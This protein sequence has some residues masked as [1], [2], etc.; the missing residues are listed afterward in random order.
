MR[1]TILSLCFFALAQ[2]LSAQ[3]TPTPA[4]ERIK[5]IERRKALEAQS[6]VQNVPFRNIGP[7]V[8]SGRVVDVDVNPNDPTEFYVAY[9][10]GGLWYTRNNGQSFKPLFDHEDVIGIGDIAV[11]WKNRQIWIGTGEVNSSRSSYPGL[12]MYFSPDSGNTWQYKG[13]PES[14]HIG[15]VVL[16]PTDPNTVWVA[17]L[18]HLFSPSSERGVFKTTDGG[19]S[20]KH[21]LAVDENTGAVEVQ[22][23]PKNPSVLYA[24]MWHRERRTWNF[25]ESGTTSGMYKSTDGGVQ[26][27]KLSVEGSGF[28]TGDGVGRIGIAVFP[29]NT[30]ILYAVV[31]NQSKRP[32]EEPKDTSVLT[33]LDL[34][35]MD[36]QQLLNTRNKKLE[37][38]LR[39]SDF[40]EKYTAESVKELVEKDSLQVQDLVD[41]LNDANN[42]LFDTP[43]IGAELY[44]SD[45]GGISWK[46]T[47]KEYMRSLYFTYGY[48]FGKVF[49]SPFDDKKVVLGGYRLIMSKDGGETF[50][51]IDGDNVHADHH[52]VWMNPVRDGHIINGN[53]GG[54]NITYDDGATWFKANTPPV[55]QFY[56][57]TTDMEEP[58]NVYGGLQDNGVWVGSSTSEI[59]NGWHDSGRNP[60]QS[61][62]GGDGM[63]IAVDTRDNTTVYTGYQFGNYYRL[64]K[65]SPDYNHPIRPRNNVGDPNYRFNWQA[66]IWLSRHNQDILYFG[67]NRFHRSMNKGDDMKTLSTDLTAADK[68]GDVPFNTITSIHESPLRFGLLYCGTDDGRVW[69][70][71]DVGY[72]WSRVDAGLPQGIYV[73]RVTASAHAEGRVYVTLNGCRSDH[74]KPYI[75]VSEDMGT[76]WSEI[77]ATLPYESVNVLREDPTDENLLYVGT[78][79]GLYISIDRGR[80][81]MAMNGGLPRVAVH[82]LMVHPRDPELVLGTHGRSLYIASLSEVR[83]LKDSLLMQPLKV[84]SAPPLDWSSHW[85]KRYGDFEDV[86][87]PTLNISYFSKESGVVSV[88]L[89]SPKG[90]SL[91]ALTDT[92]ELGINH[93]SIPL[94]VE[95]AAKQ[96]LEKELKG[97]SALVKAEDGMYYLPVFTYSLELKNASGA[98]ATQS[99]EIRKK[100]DNGKTEQG[101]RPEID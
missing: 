29:G 68:S 40:P 72:S 5:G 64:N 19:T 38:F 46:K 57:V 79:N 86:D 8:M 97:K 75:F 18:G 13:L 22:I 61:L 98:S 81:W 94:H 92:A 21:V 55:G 1:L 52:A 14:H 10:S 43:V 50:A 33:A 17:V 25:V 70:S 93:L 85:G 56:A 100:E 3:V 67:S 32:D 20:W 95:G 30:D 66:P 26:W 41:Y 35:S 65:N 71:Q 78:D 47:N 89:K 24:A 4:L 58:Y 80:N 62:L 74:F 90:V 96:A 88:S 77:G 16:H 12:G 53:D 48:Y 83:Q 15:A 44:R 84:M 99:V 101:G 45:N 37:R 60:Y 2:S 42:S 87:V 51:A 63:Q 39:Q 82:D 23:D 27:K 54:L 76:T 6:M 9:A 11:N 73:S 91:I 31:D 7:T 28:P 49:V 69:R 34:K 36:K 59:S